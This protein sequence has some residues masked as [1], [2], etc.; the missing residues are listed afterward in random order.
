M[1]KTVSFFREN[2]ES[3]II[4]NVKINDSVLHL[5]F[6]TGAT[7]TV[8]DLTALLVAGVELPKQKEMSLFETASGV[9]EAQVL[10]VPIISFANIKRPNFTLT[11]YDYLANGILS[12]IDGVLGLDFLQ[13]Y[14]FCV[15]TVKQELS[16][17]E[18]Q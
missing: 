10:N 6:D 2:D 1:S 11:T 15:D 3:L 5:A 9:L 16:F 13:G 8:I 4:V 12:D 14:K 18:I 17:T 7:H